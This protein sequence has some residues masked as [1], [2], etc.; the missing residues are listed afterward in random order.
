MKRLFYLVLVLLL[1][2]KAYGQEYKN[3]MII[4]KEP[5]PYITSLEDMAEVENNPVLYLG[6]KLEGIDGLI[7]G[8]SQKTGVYLLNANFWEKLY[9]AQPGLV[10]K[11]AQGQR[12]LDF[13]KAY[14]RFF[15][16]HPFYVQEGTNFIFSSLVKGNTKAWIIRSSSLEGLKNL[17]Y[18][19]DQAPAG[20]LSQIGSEMGLGLVFEEDYGN[21]L[22]EYLKLVEQ[23]DLYTEPSAQA[24]I[25]DQLWP[26]AYLESYGSQGGFTKIR[27]EGEFFYLKTDLT[28]TLPPEVMKVINGVL[29]VNREYSLP[30]DYEPGIHPDAHRALDDMREAMAEEGL[31]FY[32]ES[33]YRSY[34][35][36]ASIHSNFV[37]E[38]GD[39]AKTYSAEPGHSEHQTG[40]AF[41]LSSYG[42]G[43]S[44]YFEY[45]PAYEWLQ[46]NARDYGFIL[47]Y[48]ADKIDITGYVYE[49][50][51]YRH[52]GDMAVEI[53]ESG[54]SLEEFLELEKKN[55]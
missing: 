12:D 19:G 32:I 16:S 39:A 13:L 51:H 28:E 25:Y 31:G 30:A 21:Q 48:P 23:A 47:R 18:I 26:G 54:L 45:S 53:A 43:I 37:Y 34:W 17:V 50:W 35:Y 55:E 2:Q 36:Q 22:L 3:A 14:R 11:L 6:P 1:A 10:Q 41:D 8:E 44:T 24:E 29:V 49:P 5:T 9:L 7:V 52:V 38:D 46:A 20:E 33:S 4:S 15:V 27:H 40:R 42:E